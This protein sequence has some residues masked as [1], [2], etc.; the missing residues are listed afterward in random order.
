MNFSTE[1]NWETNNT[2]GSV[3]L[4]TAN[5][6]E[7]NR[8]EGGFQVNYTHQSSIGSVLSNFTSTLLVTKLDVNGTDVICEGTAGMT[9]DDDTITICIVGK[10]LYNI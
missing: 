3:F 7:N 9:A 2:G 1:I 4:Y 10:K 8:C 6:G 5:S